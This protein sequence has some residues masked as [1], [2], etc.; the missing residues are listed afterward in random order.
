MSDPGDQRIY[1]VEV[2]VTK[3]QG[4]SLF[5][6]CN[7]ETEINLKYLEKLFGEH[8]FVCCIHF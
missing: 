6:I 1:K 3:T 4:L 2:Y 5:K 8:Y 7:C